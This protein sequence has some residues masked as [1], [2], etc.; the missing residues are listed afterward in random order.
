MTITNNTNNDAATT[1]ELTWLTLAQLAPHP[2]NPRRRLG[3]L[4]ELTRSI[5]SHGVLE[6]FLVLPAND[7]GV[8]TI[9]AGHRR[10]AAARIVDVG[11]VPV[12]IRDL[13]PIEALEAMIAEN[14]IRND[15][16]ITEEIVAIERLLCLDG[17]LTPAKLCRQI[18]K[19]QQWVR[20]RMTLSV[21]PEIARDALDEGTMAL[22]AAVA[23]SSVAD[24]GPDH[25]QAVC[26]MLIERRTGD[27]TRQVQRYRDDLNR[28]ELFNT[29][30]DKHTRSGAR[31]ITDRSDLPRSAHTLHDLHFDTDQAQAHRGEPCHAVLITTSSW[32]TEPETT[33]TCL[34]PSRHR[35]SGRGERSE[36]ILD[37]P[38][39]AE[40]TGPVNPDSSAA[41]R[42]GRVAR[43][44]AAR[45]Q[46]TGRG[47]PTAA[48]FT[49]YGL[50]TL[51]DQAGMEARKY[52]ATMLGIDPPEQADWHELTA[53][54][55]TA[56]QLARL[57]GAVA[58]GIAETRAYHAPNASTV[59]TW[60]RLLATHGW[61]PDGWTTDRLNGT[62]EIDTDQDN[63]TDDTGN[64][65]DDID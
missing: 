2:Q 54:A 52:A 9:V 61:E 27:P 58:C 65:D 47:G 25:L 36:I 60:F 14:V 26:S 56:A 63:D 8:H 13:S 3:N 37:T 53:T 4:D 34:E 31:V 20:D 23:A 12:L 49:V 43:L 18:G 46:F 57:A 50:H 5:R 62:S 29:A 30:V 24:L 45:E 42:K 7:V 55:S 39:P 17:G 16:T 41:R 33:P 1:T 44:A 40:R 15:L 38:T 6:P 32:R 35:P 22:A 19:S 21:L 64:H 48:E 11:S 10:F 59:Q 51:I 28:T